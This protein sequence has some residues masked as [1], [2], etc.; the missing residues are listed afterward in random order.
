MNNPLV[1]TKI[2][3]RGLKDPRT[4]LGA[5]LFAGAHHLTRVASHDEEDRG[6]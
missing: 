6:T 3:V 4:I 5:L 2:D 1:L